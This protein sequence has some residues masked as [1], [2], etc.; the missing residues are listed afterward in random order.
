[1]EWSEVEIHS[2]NEAIEPIAN[3]LTEYGASG[4]AIIDVADFFKEHE[5][6][7]GEIYALDREDYPEDGVIIRAYFLTN[8]DFLNTLP[9]M[10]AAIRNLTTFDI[11]L[12]NL[13]FFVHEV[14]DEEWATAWKKYYHPVQIS[15]QITVV[16]TWEDYVAQEG[17]LIIELD[18]GMAFGTGTHPTT[19]LC[20]RALEK[21]VQADDFIIDVGTGS[22]V[23]SI[24]SVKLGAKSVLALDLDEVAVRAA[25]E[26]IKQNHVAK[27]IELKQNDLLKGIDQKADI[28]VANILAEVILLFPNDVYHTLKPG[29]LF[30]ASGII[31]EKAKAV[32]EVLSKA[33]LTVIKQEQ[34]GDWVMILARRGEV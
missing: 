16:P 23:L 22:G 9:E 12:G 26:N 4:V 33:G 3:L 20:M 5:D 15:E 29:A 6:K 21:Y 2:I 18:P 7:F 10:E 32:S 28:I 14:N 25:S 24:L 8:A 11:D 27:K 17:E 13:A 31:L 19:Q 34:Q 30:I 1:M